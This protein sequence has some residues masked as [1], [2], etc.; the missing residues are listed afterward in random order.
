MPSKNESKA[1]T[2]PEDGSFN[3][4]VLSLK[5]LSL[6]YVQNCISTIYIPIPLFP[7]PLYYKPLFPILLLQYFTRMAVIAIFVV[8]T[9]TSLSYGS[10]LRIENLWKA[11]SYSFTLISTHKYR[12]IQ[13]YKF[14]NWGTNN[15]SHIA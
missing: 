12:Y 15:R 11:Y 2:W 10:F 4:S 7:I 13:L 9:N 6:L 8:H 14:K 3:I 1:G 5:E